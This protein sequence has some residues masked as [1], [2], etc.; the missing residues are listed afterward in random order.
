MKAHINSITIKRFQLWERHE[1]DIE[2]FSNKLN[3]SPFSANSTLKDNDA[4]RTFQST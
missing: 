1:S 3:L 2:S 4:N